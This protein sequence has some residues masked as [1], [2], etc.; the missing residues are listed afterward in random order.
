[1]GFSKPKHYL[2][3]SRQPLWHQQ[4]CVSVKVLFVLAE[5]LC[6]LVITEAFPE[7]SGLF[8]C[9]VLNSFGT[10]SC[11]AMLEVYDGTICLYL[12]S[13][14]IRMCLSH[15]H[16]SAFVQTWRSS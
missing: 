2:T 1:M 5:E 9:V 14:F 8:K 3:D 10:V 4:C 16:A 12:P 7:D 13:Q 11:V 15:F 6:T